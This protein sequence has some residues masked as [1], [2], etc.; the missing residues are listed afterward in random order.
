MT[1][2]F[3]DE[4]CGSGPEIGLGRDGAFQESERLR[5]RTLARSQHRR[6]DLRDDLDRVEGSRPLDLQKGLQR[7]RDGGPD[8]ARGER[9]VGARPRR[10]LV[11]RRLERLVKCRVPLRAELA[12]AS[13]QS[14]EARV[15]QALA[16]QSSLVAQLDEGGTPAPAFRAVLVVRG[17]AVLAAAL[18]FEDAPHVVD[19][20]VGIRA[21]DIDHALPSP[22]ACLG[23][24]IERPRTR[25]EGDGVRVGRRLA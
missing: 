18:D 3:G 14:V 25:D 12:E 7:H 4:A 13:L 24:E 15:E 23:G 6:S 19:Q 2:C 16:A 21:Q 1:E 10:T 9:E 20:E 17:E 11:V 5:G 8:W 22:R